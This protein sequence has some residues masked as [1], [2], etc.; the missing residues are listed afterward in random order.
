MTFREA[1]C[2]E[3][4]LANGLETAV[5]SKEG[6]TTSR[7]RGA[8]HETPCKGLQGR[9]PSFCQSKKGS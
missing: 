1:G 6:P 9:E 3:T 5:R 8:G 4:R 2:L 7:P